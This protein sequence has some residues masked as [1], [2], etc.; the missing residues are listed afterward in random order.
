M[1]NSPPKPRRR[2]FQFS[3][4]TLLALFTGICICAAVWANSAN[5]QRRA[6]EVIGQD[7]Y[8]VYWHEWP[9]PF[10]QSDFRAVNY[11]A[12]PSGPRWL[13]RL[14]GDEYFRT[15]RSVCFTP[16]AFTLSKLGELASV[17]T[18]S[19]CAVQLKDEDF[20]HLSR[21]QSLK[22][23][24]IVY[25][26]ELT[27]AFLSHLTDLENLQCLFVNNTPITD[28]SI[29]YLKQL[30]HLN[31]LTLSDT[32]ISPN[33]AAELRSALPSARPYVQGTYQ[34]FTPRPNYREFPTDDLMRRENR[35]PGP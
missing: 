34:P 4:G 29:P 7:G 25:G 21:M 17:D 24:W 28:G 30:S 1:V 3:L 10:G 33:G 26:F 35:R 15:V 14:V 23:I 11:A 8:V 5:R 22:Q 31:Q 2:W 16:E 12:E 9:A 13:R 18:V 6:V 19:I 27:D 20:K 32:L